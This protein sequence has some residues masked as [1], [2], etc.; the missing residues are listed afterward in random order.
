MVATAELAASGQGLSVLCPGEE[1][2][3]S[4]ITIE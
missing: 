3:E 1:V 4:T 2:D